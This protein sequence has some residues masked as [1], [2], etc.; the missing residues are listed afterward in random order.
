M[1]PVV[2]EHKQKRIAFINL[3][4]ASLY[5]EDAD[6]YIG[7]AEIDTHMISR[8]F[9]DLGYQVE[10][11]INAPHQGRRTWEQDGFVIHNFPLGTITI[12]FSCLRKLWRMMKT[13]DAPIWFTKIISP[14]SA[15]LG[16]FA[17]LY[18]RKFIYKTANERD[19][20]LARGQGS[21]PLSQRLCFHLTRWGISAYIAQ[22]ESQKQ[23]AARWFRSANRT[24]A[25]IPN[26]HAPAFGSALPLSER[27]YVLWVGHLKRVKRPWLFFKLAE[28][29]PETKFLMVAATQ[30]N[31]EAGQYRQRADR[32]SNLTLIENVPFPR[33]MDYFYQA[34]VLVN[35]S[36]SEGFPNTFLQAFQSLTP[37]LTTG[38]DP[39]GII[40]DEQLGGV[41]PDVAKM[42]AWLGKILEDPEQYVRI[43][44]NLERYA[45]E[46]ISYELAKQEYRR[47]LE[48]I[49]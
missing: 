19:L 42:S 38:V 8:I 7:G 28:A 33:M 23:G 15:V 26:V 27:E 14:V 11:V 40:A 34:Q 1:K 9:L 4:G 10:V 12:S 39:D 46:H 20:L 16:V 18:R 17:G 32:L 35:T 44:K 43:Q 25:R 22:N 31:V 41:A 6:G 3:N 24:L 45:R 13:V 5:L 30:K 49:K 48:E 36:E 37:L 21:Y 2:D 47:V 29:M